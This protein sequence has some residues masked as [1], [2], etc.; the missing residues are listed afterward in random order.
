MHP[1]FVKLADDCLL[2]VFG[3]IPLTQ[4]F[5]WGWD[6]P[7]SPGASSKGS[8]SNPTSAINS[9][10]PSPGPSQPTTSQNPSGPSSGEPSNP[11]GAI[12]CELTGDGVRYR[13]C[14]EASSNCPAYGQYEVGHMVHFLCK[15][16]GELIEGNPYVLNHK[17][18][19]L[20]ACE[21]SL[22]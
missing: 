12:V 14:R 8:G 2:Q 19:I 9:P 13:P 3:P 17:L 1:I 21:F 6:D 11:T 22:C 4:P 20:T 5:C 16:Q 15:E 7:N 18:F 10:V